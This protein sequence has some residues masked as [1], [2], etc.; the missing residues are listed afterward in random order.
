M[1]LKDVRDRLEAIRNATRGGNDA[2]CH[3]MQD[4]LWEAVLEA[5]AGGCG[6]E[7]ELA[8]EALKVRDIEFDRW[9]E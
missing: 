6:N 3:I 9:Y 5:V 4:E 2:Q 7:V 8:R 1:T